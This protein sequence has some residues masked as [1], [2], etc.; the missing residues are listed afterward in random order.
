MLCFY[1]LNTVVKKTELSELEGSRLLYAK[2]FG[3]KKE[4]DDFLKREYLTYKCLKEFSGLEVSIIG[5]PGKKPSTSSKG[6]FF[7][8]STD[9]SKF[10]I[11]VSNYLCGVDIKEVSEI[12]IDVIKY[13][14]TE[15]ENKFLD[16]IKD[17]KQKRIYYTL[18]YTIKES[19][20]KTKNLN[21]AKSL[22]KINTKL[23]SEVITESV[24]RIFSTN[25]LIDGVYINSYYINGSIITISTTKDVYSDLLVN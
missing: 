16:C 2:K 25:L 20:I 19:I 11:Y 18:I 3:E 6:L 22:L 4:L 1:D 9:G 5:L 21:R 7:S 15:K 17:L 10:V 12:D 24:K 23:K 14:F 13:T 8:R